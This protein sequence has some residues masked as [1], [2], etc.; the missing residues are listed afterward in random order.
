G[1]VQISGGPNFSVGKVISVAY[2]TVNRRGW[3]RHSGNNLWNSNAANDPATNVGGYDLSAFNGPMAIAARVYQNDVFTIRTR[4]AEFTQPIPAGY[5]SWMGEP[6]T[7]ATAD[8]WNVYDKSTDITL[9]NGDKTATRTAIT[10][11]ASINVR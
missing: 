6:T 2:D 10:G 9:S 11:S 5:L 3:I 7:P 1:G 4:A 8:A